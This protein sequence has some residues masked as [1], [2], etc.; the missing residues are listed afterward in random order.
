MMYKKIVYE[1][2]IA[3]IIWK[4]K[5]LELCKN[6]LCSTL[7]HC[8]IYCSIG[9]YRSSYAVVCVCSIYPPSS[10][11]GAKSYK[12]SDAANFSMDV[13]TMFCVYESIGTLW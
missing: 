6:V 4:H 8:V 7:S 9:S 2:Y 13:V 12:V 3:Y 5:N 10:W 11:A 1:N